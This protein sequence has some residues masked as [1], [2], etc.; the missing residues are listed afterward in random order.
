[1]TASEQATHEFAAQSTSPAASRRFVRQTLREWG[2]HSILDDAVL[3]TNE[4]VTNA[5]VHAG[6]AL[7]V[8][9][10]LGAGYVQIGVSDSHAARALPTDVSNA[11]EE[12]T[13]GRGLY[14]ISQIAEAWGVEYDRTGKRVWFRLPL[15]D[16]PAP[17][18]ITPQPTHF[19]DLGAA[20]APV[21]VAVVETDPAGKVGHWSFEAEQLL[22]WPEAE[23]RG[24]ALA[25]LVASMAPGPEHPTLAEALALPRWRGECALRSAHGEEITVFVSQ[26]HACAG[27]EPRVV[28]LLVPAGHRA[29]LLH[30]SGPVP[31]SP[32]PSAAVPSRPGLL[33]LESLLELAV[34]HSRDLLDGDVAYALLVTDDDLDVELRAATS[35]EG[36]PPMGSR[37]RKPP[38][39]T[40]AGDGLPEANVYAD[41]AEHPM[42][43]QFLGEVGMHALT[44][45]PLRVGERVIGRVGV[46]ARSPGVFT[47]DDA[48]RLQH[49]VDRFSLAIESARL[50]ELERAR[51]GRLSY[52]AEASDL[53]AGVLDPDMAAALTAQLVVPR[54]ADWCAVYLCDQRRTQRLACVWHAR[55]EV[56]DPLRSLL[57]RLPA[58]SLETSGHPRPWPAL[59]GL[60]AEVTHD[61][62][63][64]QLVDG[65]A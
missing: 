10:A 31:E 20:D 50:N 34:E 24:R 57:L 44:M 18:E 35:P 55:E 59:R 17:P 1:M 28:V 25:D 56:L 61:L 2:A 27:E 41:L 48:A 58:P 9:C 30:E 51:R 52:L 22:G 42:P 11:P 7:S 19:V 14:L 23:M 62:A 65:P 39:L 3:L 32:E 26:V 45:A 12:K 13:S 37:W 49:S 53:L 16:T 54:L 4:L 6:T 15:T 46:A 36:L 64:S 60:V 63:E 40:G 43:E 33:P 38:T 8:S 47:A 5:V 29:V 21:R